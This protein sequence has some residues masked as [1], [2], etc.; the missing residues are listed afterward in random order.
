MDLKNSLLGHLLC[1]AQWP[2]TDCTLECYI[3]RRLLWIYAFTKSFYIIFED[4][5]VFR[6]EESSEPSK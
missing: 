1:T 4:T 6:Q 2:V 3:E 5:F